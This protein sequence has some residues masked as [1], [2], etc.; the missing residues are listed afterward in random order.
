MWRYGHNEKNYIFFFVIQLL[1]TRDNSHTNMTEKFIQDDFFF[2]KE[3]K[4]EFLI[5]N[6][7]LFVIVTWYSLSPSTNFKFWKGFNVLYS[8]FLYVHKRCRFPH[9]ERIKSLVDYLLE[10]MFLFWSVINLSTKF[11]RA[12]ERRGKKTHP[13][14][15]QLL[16]QNNRQSTEYEEHTKDHSPFHVIVDDD[17]R[18]I[19]FKLLHYKYYVKCIW[20]ILILFFRSFGIVFSVFLSSIL[21]KK[22]CSSDIF[23]NKSIHIC[24]F[25]HFNC[26]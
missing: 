2:K 1:A 8:S 23:H 13:I 5:T 16:L 11:Q 26:S 20:C 3:Q 10:S 25:C 14:H 21:K 24:H 22:F 17:S 12:F 7:A 6:T 18:F 9:C 4:I 19:R 15:L